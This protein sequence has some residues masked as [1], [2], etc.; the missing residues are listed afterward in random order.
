MESSSLNNSTNSNSNIPT[1]QVLPAKRTKKINTKERLLLLHLKQI[2][3][4]QEHQEKLQEAERKSQNGDSSGGMFLKLKSRKKSVGMEN[5]KTRL[6]EEI[7]QRNKQRLKKIYMPPKSQI[8][9]EYCDLW[10]YYGNQLYKDEKMGRMNNYFENKI[11]P[12]VG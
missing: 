10:K 2:G 11:H 4:V 9:V 12:F 8:N 6:N 5:A 3:K 1:T 7:Y